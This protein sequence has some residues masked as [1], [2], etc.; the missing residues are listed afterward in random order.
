MNI[1]HI[2]N[3]EKFYDQH[4]NELAAVGADAFGQPVDIFEPQVRER[5]SKAKMAQIMQDGRLIIGF[6]LYDT[7]RGSHWRFAF[8]RG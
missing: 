3:P 1:H 6:A 5:F 7:I 2:T 4:G 8:H